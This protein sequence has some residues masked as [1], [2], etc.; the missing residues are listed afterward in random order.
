MNAKEL[1]QAGDLT[2]AIAAAAEE[3]KRRPTD[4]SPRGFLAELLCF[5]GEL[6]RADTHL[7]V[8]VQQDIELAVGIAVFRQLIRAE[9]ARRQ[10]FSDG[11][12]PEFLQ[13]PSDRLRYHLEA[14]IRL[15][16][17]HEEEAAAMLDDAEQKRPAVAGVCDGQPLDDFRDIDDLLASLFEVYTTTGKY[18]W[19]PIEH[20]ELIEFRPPQRPR[21]LLWRPAHMIVR[22]GPDGEVF[23]PVIYPPAPGDADD[24]IRLGRMTDWRGGEKAPVRGRGQRMFVVGQEDR[25]ILELGTITFNHPES[26]Q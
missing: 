25:S 8:L 24:R 22:D 10:F 14:S 26:G 2:G 4:P 3:V 23:L 15:R 9:Q 18:Y 1:Y 11:R 21:D 6:E 16:E 19:V 7:D 5:A 13:P 17:G 12:L 20:V